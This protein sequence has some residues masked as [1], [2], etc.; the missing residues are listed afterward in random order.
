MCQRHKQRPRADRSAHGLPAGRQG[1]LSSDT[2]EIRLIVSIWSGGLDLLRFTQ[3]QQQRLDRQ[4]IEK[5]TISPGLGSTLSTHSGR[6]YENPALNR[7]ACQLGQRDRMR[8][9]RYSCVQHGVEDW[10][11]ARGKTKSIVP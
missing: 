5:V 6:L 10:S 7:M 4:I 1:Q 11:K 8:P 9:F 2:A 3:R